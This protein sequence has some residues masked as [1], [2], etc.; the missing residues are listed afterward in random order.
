MTNNVVTNALLA[1]SGL[2]ARPTLTSSLGVPTLASPY[3]NVSNLRASQQ[4]ANNVVMDNLRNSQALAN[5]QLTASTLGVGGLG[6][7]G[8]GYGRLGGYGG[9]NRGQNLGL[10]Y[11]G[12]GYSGA[13]TGAYTGAYGL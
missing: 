6:Y 4:L 9:Y 12:L 10:G 5:A 1:R 13:Y 7:S 8:L 3:A 2:W 11:G